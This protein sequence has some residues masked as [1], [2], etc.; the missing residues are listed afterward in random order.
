MMPREIQA[1]SLMDVEA[2]LQFTVLVHIHTT[3]GLGSKI[4][5]R[6]G[7]RDI[8]PWRRCGFET[9]YQASFHM[10]ESRRTVTSLIG[11]EQ[12]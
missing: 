1:E 3:H 7:E 9:S 2:S 12:K 6:G 11:E 10:P 4:R 5:P 8:R